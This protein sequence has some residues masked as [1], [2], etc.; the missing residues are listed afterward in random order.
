MDRS[1]LCVSIKLYWNKAALFVHAEP[2]AGFC[3]VT[4]G[5][6]AVTGMPLLLCAPFGPATLEEVL[7]G[8]AELILQGSGGAP[9]Q[10]EEPRNDFPQLPG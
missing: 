6:V 2:V 10:R 1:W 7:S 8:L 3:S 9:P 4:A 5:L